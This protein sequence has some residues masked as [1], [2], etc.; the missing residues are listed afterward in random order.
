M[1]SSLSAYRKEEVIRAVGAGLA[2]T[3]K[4]KLKKLAEGVEYTTRKEFAEQLLNLKDSYFPKA[5]KP[6]KEEPLVE[7][8]NPGTSDMDVYAS[9][10][11]KFR[12]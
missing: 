3:Q 11:S 8:K 12:K 5:A 2:D 10:L 7:Q 1:R 9:V 6:K 4:D